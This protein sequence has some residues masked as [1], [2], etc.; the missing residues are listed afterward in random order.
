MSI[1]QILNYQFIN[2]HF[3][4][5]SNN[6]IIQMS[7]LGIYTLLPKYT[8]H[9][10]PPLLL[11]YYLQRAPLSQ[12]YQCIHRKPRPR[13]SLSYWI[14]ILQKG[15]LPKYYLS[16][17]HCWC[18]HQPHPWIYHNI[19]AYNNQTYHYI[20]SVIQPPWIQYLHLLGWLMWITYALTMKSLLKPMEDM[21]L[22][23]M[24]K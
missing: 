11:L 3:G 24:D 8:P 10:I 9:T 14:Q 18:Y 12:A 19:K 17:H 23:S 20:H 22:Q 2:Q 15:L 13:Y 16:P 4:H 1:I 5:D 6:C 7:K 21:P